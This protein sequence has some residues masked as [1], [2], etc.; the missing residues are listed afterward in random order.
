MAILALMSKT[1]SIRL[2]PLSDSTMLIIAHRGNSAIAPENTL[3]AV[4][5][6]LAVAVDGIEIDIQQVDDKLLVFHDRWLHR[7]TNGKGLLA[8]HSV[9][10]LM[11]LDAGEGQHIPT[12]IE[13]LDLVGGRCRLNIEIKSIKDVELLIEALDYAQ[14]QCQFSSQQL[15]ISSFSHH[16][17]KQVKGLRPHT[18][19]GALTASCPIEMCNFAQQLKAYSVHLNM[20][21]VTEELIKD[22]K[23]RGLQV[24]VYTVDEVE[25]KFLL[26]SWGA[27]GIFTNVPARFCGLS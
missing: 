8:D 24:Y 12:L 6:A 20:E 7:T 9:E 10:R 3:L 4:E 16:V 2:N 18:L 27:D 19:I 23:A 26:E 14:E 21:S 1:I 15:I 25:D 5:K 17:L 11:T 13:V 22:G